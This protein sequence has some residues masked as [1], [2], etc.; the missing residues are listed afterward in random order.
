M[1]TFCF[2][3]CQQNNPQFYWGAKNDFSNKKIA[4]YMRAN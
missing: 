2:V 4:S 1:F 3:L